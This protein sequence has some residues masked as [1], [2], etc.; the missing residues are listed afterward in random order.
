[1]NYVA[2]RSMGC[3]RCDK[4]LEKLGDDDHEARARRIFIIILAIVTVALVIR[5]YLPKGQI[6]WCSIAR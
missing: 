4:S 6:A 2:F 1:M 3:R 5:G